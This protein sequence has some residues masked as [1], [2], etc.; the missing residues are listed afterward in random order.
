MIKDMAA[1]EKNILDKVADSKE[2][3]IDNQFKMRD[4]IERLEK[5]VDLQNKMINDIKAE[6]D[7]FKNYDRKP[8]NA[9]RILIRSLFS[10]KE[11]DGITI[12]DSFD[13]IKGERVID[14]HIGKMIL[15]NEDVNGLNKVLN[16]KLRFVFGEDGIKRVGGILGTNSIRF[17][18][19][20]WYFEEYKKLKF[21]EDVD[22]FEEKSREMLATFRIPGEVNN[23]SINKANKKRKLYA[24]Y[25]YGC[26]ESGFAGAVSRTDKEHWSHYKSITKKVDML[27]IVKNGIGLMPRM[28]MCYN[29]DDNQLEMA[30]EWLIG[31]KKQNRRIS[32]SVFNK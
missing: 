25:C 11:A 15:K 23:K 27:K 22:G 2:L 10:I 4:V 3:A 32:K 16:H 26:H 14:I 28:G 13:K 5:K 12:L 20:K 19:N 7:F 30:I 31:E 17:L 9:I 18:L 24:K 8:D 29:C 1:K 21:G 6:N